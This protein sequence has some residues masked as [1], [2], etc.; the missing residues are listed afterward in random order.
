MPFIL[1]CHRVCV[2]ESS[3]WLI[4]QDFSPNLNEGKLVLIPSPSC[5]AFGGPALRFCGAPECE[6]LIKAGHE[7]SQV[8]MGAGEVEGRGDGWPKGLIWPNSKIL[9]CL[10]I[11]RSSHV[12]AIVKLPQ[13][14]GTTILNF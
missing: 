14:L 8:E 11:E 2:S 5:K 3:K 6:E 13:C 12:K 10:Y 7:V 1:L 9:L 4:V